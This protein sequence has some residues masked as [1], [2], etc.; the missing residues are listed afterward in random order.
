MQPRRSMLGIV[1]NYEQHKK[2]ALV[3]VGV[4]RTDRQSICTTVNVR[5]FGDCWRQ[6]V[7]PIHSQISKC[8]FPAWTSIYR[9]HFA[10]SSTHIGIQHSRYIA[11][12]R[13]IV[14][15]VAKHIY[16]AIHSVKRNKRY[17]FATAPATRPAPVGEPYP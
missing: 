10:Q 14:A 1:Y 17:Y 13:S 12:K 11:T 16:G 7:L 4:S 15:I 8:I 6:I 5:R 3:A 9:Q 2:M